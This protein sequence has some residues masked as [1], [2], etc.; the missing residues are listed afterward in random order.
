MT[1]YPT[2]KA[3]IPAKSRITL[4]TRIQLAIPKGYLAAISSALNPSPLEPLF[5]PG[6]LGPAYSDELILL[7]VNLTDKTLVVDPKVPI[8][9]VHLTLAGDI[10]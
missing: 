9:Y 7:V 3:G 2:V 5:C 10:T 4:P 1:I 8:A 6:V